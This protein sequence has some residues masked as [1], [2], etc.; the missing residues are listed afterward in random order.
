[1]AEG[2]RLESVYTARYP[3]FESLSLRHTPFHRSSRTSSIAHGTPSNQ[4]SFCLLWSYVVYHNRA[5]DPVLKALETSAK[6]LQAKGKR[7]ICEDSENVDSPTPLASVSG[8][9]CLRL[10][11]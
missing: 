3:G 1:M 5:D 4:W 9:K 8:R 7:L 10:D 2:A 11:L 6:Q